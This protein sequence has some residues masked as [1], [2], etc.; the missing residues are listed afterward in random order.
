MRLANP[1]HRGWNSQIPKAV[2][3]LCRNMEAQI[4]AGDPVHAKLSIKLSLSEWNLWCDASNQ[5]CRCVCTTTLTV[6]TDSKTVHD[7]MKSL[8][9]NIIMSCEGRWAVQSISTSHRSC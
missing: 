9:L 2:E 3:K 7:W 1:S 4:A 6:N 5:A 8:L